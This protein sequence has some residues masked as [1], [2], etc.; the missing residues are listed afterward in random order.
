MNSLV[1]YTIN[2]KLSEKENNSIEQKR[3]KKI[4]VHILWFAKS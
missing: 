2:N 4:P 1:S 3:L